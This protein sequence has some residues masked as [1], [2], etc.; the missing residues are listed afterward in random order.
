[1]GKPVWLLLAHVPDWRWMMERSDTPW[2]P[3][4]RVIRQPRPG[5]WEGIINAAREDLL[6][7]FVMSALGQKRTLG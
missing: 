7:G 1:M 4:V 2:Y 5:D 3:D 6:Q